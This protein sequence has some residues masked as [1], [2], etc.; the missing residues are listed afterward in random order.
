MIIIRI[1]RDFEMQRTEHYIKGER[2]KKKW[3]RNGAGGE[4][5]LGATVAGLYERGLYRGR[6]APN[7]A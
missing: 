4:S 6:N 1:K 2:R 3:T 5:S 7:R